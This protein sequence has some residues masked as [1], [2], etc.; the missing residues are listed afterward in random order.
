[1]PTP[2]QLPGNQNEPLAETS[3][4][5]ALALEFRP[6]GVVRSCY[7]GRF[8]VPRQPRL[9]TAAEARLELL[10]EFAR[11]EAFAGLEGFSHVWLIFVFHD[12]PGAGWSPTVRP[13]RLGGRRKVGVFAS[14]SP[15]RPNP[16]GISAVRLIGLER[17]PGGPRSSTSSRMSPTRTRFRMRVRALRRKLPA[18]HGR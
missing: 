6:I 3:D 11:E 15:Y 8:G 13:P 14:R 7:T 4:L 5:Y 18:R 17:R 10:P 16:I 2:R 9:V 12:C 1:M